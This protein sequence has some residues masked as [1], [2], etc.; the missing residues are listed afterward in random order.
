MSGK[1]DVFSVNHSKGP[2]VINMSCCENKK[3]ICDRSTRPVFAG[4][5]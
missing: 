5:V 2:S 3:D 4:K 1:I